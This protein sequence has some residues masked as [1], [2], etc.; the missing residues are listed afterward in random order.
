MHETNASDRRFN[1]RIRTLQIV[2]STLLVGVLVFLGIVLFLRPGQGGARLPGTPVVSCT[3]LVFLVS[4]LAVWFFLPAHLAKRQVR[5]IADG[6]WIPGSPYPYS[7][8]WGWAGPGLPLAAFPTDADKLLAVF[9]TTSLV[10]WAL[11]NGPAFMGCIAYLL[12]GEPFALGVIGVPVLLFLVTFPTRG[13][14]SRWLAEQQARVNEIRQG[15]GLPAVPSNP[16]DAEIRQLKERI[17][18]LEAQKEECG[19]ESL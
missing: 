18:E 9:Q 4:V 15:E 10:G 12:E 3:A 17:A 11:L 6:T 16:V 19:D 5:K 1:A 2:A 13:R 8:Y 14:I 7:L